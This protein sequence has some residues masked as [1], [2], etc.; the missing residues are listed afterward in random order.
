M[1]TSLYGPN[2]NFDPATSH[3]LPTLIRRLAEAVR[4]GLSEVRVWGTGNA[5]RE[6]LHSDDVAD[7]C[8]FLA[9]VDHRHSL[10]NVG[11]GHEISIRELAELVARVTG[12][13]G[14][15]VFD[16]GMPDGTYRKLLDSRRA[17][18]LG[19]RPSVS[20]EAGLRQLYELWLESS[21]QANGQGEAPS[22]RSAG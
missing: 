8:V 11:S 9:A 3:V 20:L 17:T 12:F 1:P 7:A 22:R 14:E 10:V 19:W 13:A 5:L 6:F 21:A 2:D 4:L 15:I 16:A 18:M